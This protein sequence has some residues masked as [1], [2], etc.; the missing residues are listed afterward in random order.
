MTPYRQDTAGTRCLTEEYLADGMTDD[1]I[2]ALD[3]RQEYDRK[4]TMETIKTIQARGYR[5][6][7]PQSKRE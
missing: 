2:A 6:T 1:L 3:I 7:K 4:A 5:I